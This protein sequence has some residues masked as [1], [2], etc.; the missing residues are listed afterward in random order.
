MK[1]LLSSQSLTLAH[2]G[3]ILVDNVTLSISA[4]EFVAIM[5]ANGAGKSSLLRLLAGDCESTHGQVHWLKQPLLSLK[6]DEKAR[7]MAYLPQQSALRFPFHVRDVVALG[8][9]PHASSQVENSALIQQAMQRMDVFD[10]RHRDYLTL[11][12]GEQQRVQ[13]ARVLTQ[14]ESSEP[15][16]ACLLLDEPTSALDLRHQHTVMASLRRLTERGIAVIVVMHDSNLAL[17][18]ADRIALLHPG[19]LLFDGKP[20]EA[21]TPERVRT[22]FGV[23]SRL[24]RDEISGQSHLITFS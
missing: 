18:Y 6:P 7:C 10:L 21:L 17:N 13:L 16:N 24:I 20:L 12:G 15:S 14:I 11:S 9:L 22:A 8:R 19:R 4:G 1:T 23:N 3:K 2:H 5:G